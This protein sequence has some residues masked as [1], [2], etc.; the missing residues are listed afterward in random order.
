MADILIM[1]ETLVEIMREQEDIQL[2]EA[3]VFRGPYPSGAPAICADA[4]ARL[5]C[6]TVLISGVG[7]DDFG[8]CVL[9]RLKRDGV[10][11]SRVIIDKTCA[12]GCAFVTYFSDGSRKFIFHMGN[13][14][15]VRAKA[16]LKETLQSVKYMHIM[17]CSLMA[18]SGFAVEI[19]KTMEM[20][21]QK[22]AKISFDPNIRA[23][24]LRENGFD[25]ILEEVMNCTSILLPGRGELLSLM[26]TDSVEEAVS[27]C[28]RYPKMEMILLKNGSRGSTLYTKEGLIKEYGVYKVQQLDATGAG[29]CFDGAFLAGIVQGKTLDEAVKIGAAAGALNAAAFGPMEGNINWE[30]VDNL[31][32]K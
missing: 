7:D 25:E 19:L 28:F 5:G 8:K 6:N 24:L 1:G 17:G 20:C 22:G 4:A 21:I 27:N 9:E 32:M 29:D 12:T 31:I 3:G 15:A 23:E 14:P 16:P 10:D 11:V 13:T 2:Y 18:D 26:K 30:A